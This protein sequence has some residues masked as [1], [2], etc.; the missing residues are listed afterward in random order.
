MPCSTAY[1]C[2]NPRLLRQPETMIRTSALN[3]LAML[4]MLGCL[5]G[6]AQAQSDER[7]FQIEFTVFGNESISD[8]ERETWQA[9]RL[10][11]AYP[12]GMMRL[13][14]VADLLFLDLFSP[15]SEPEAE[16][17]PVAEFNSAAGPEPP[18]PD[19]ARLRDTGPFPASGNNGFRFPDLQRDPFLAL[20][21]SLSDFRQSNQAIERAPQ[22]RILYRGLWRQP[23]GDAGATIPIHVS[24]GD[25]RGTI[26]ELQ[27]SV[28]IYFNENRDRV[29][30]RTN[31]WISEFGALS[32]NAET[33]AVPPLP[34]AFGEPATEPT[35]PQVRRVYPMQQQ[36][37]LRS[38][39][40]HYL[41]HPA[42]GIVVLLTPYELPPPIEQSE[43]EF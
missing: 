30:F 6:N 11:L 8:R 5:A 28:A 13:G 19:L 43:P 33:W 29:I 14:Q 27:G 17:A 18:A 2:A 9:G 24:G 31:L 25:R 37:E 12:P 35:E 4:F 26:S 39:E 40:F 7:W 41:D 34:D 15:E 10:Q 3:H 38:G 32:G 36:R 22:H 16:L 23:V 21:A 42:M 1:G 20:P